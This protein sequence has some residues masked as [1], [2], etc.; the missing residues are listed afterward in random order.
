MTGYAAVRCPGNLG[1]E[2]PSERHQQF[3]PHAAGGRCSGELEQ[4]LM[5]AIVAVE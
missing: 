1:L 5:E 2:W 4:K 3:Q